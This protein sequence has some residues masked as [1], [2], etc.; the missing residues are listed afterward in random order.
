[1]SSNKISYQQ[2]QV[3]VHITWY[4]NIYKNLNKD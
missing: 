3:D 4:I 2:M 1:M